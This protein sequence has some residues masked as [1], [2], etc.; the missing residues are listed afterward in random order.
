MLQKLFGKVI[1]AYIPKKGDNIRD[2]IVLT[3]E[4]AKQGGPYAYHHRAK[5]KK[6][7]VHVPTGVRNAQ[8]IRLAGMGQEG[9]HGAAAGDLL[10]KVKIREP[11]LKK[12]K[13]LINL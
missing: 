10:L 12:L 11:F 5:D 7:V 2:V 13:K 8:Q 3:P 9:T 1:G 4:L 6:L